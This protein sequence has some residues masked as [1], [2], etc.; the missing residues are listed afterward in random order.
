MAENLTPK[1]YIDSNNMKQILTA[2]KNEIHSDDLIKTK[3][4]SG[5]SSASGNF[6]LQLDDKY[7]VLSANVVGST[8]NTYMIMPYLSNANTW[9][10]TCVTLSESDVLTREKNVPFNMR[11]TYIE[12]P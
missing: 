1:K 6:N 10:A 8:N 3:V 7:V 11:V 5:T 9:W 2:V 12:L 4:I